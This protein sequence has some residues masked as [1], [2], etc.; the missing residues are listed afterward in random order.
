MAF[1]LRLTTRGFRLELVGMKRALDDYM[2]TYYFGGW[3]KRLPDHPQ[4]D[5]YDVMHRYHHQGK[6]AFGSMIGY[7]Y[8]S[9]DYGYYR[10]KRHRDVYTILEYTAWERYCEQYGNSHLAL[11]ESKKVLPAGWD[12]RMSETG[13]ILYV[14]FLPAGEVDETSPFPVQW[15]EHTPTATLTD[16]LASPRIKRR[17]PEDHG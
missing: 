15:Q 14:Q 16:S 6:G 8:F 9:E 2:E 12:A 5:W 11:K 3:P 4:G 7:D 17:T 10:H 1:A 13:K